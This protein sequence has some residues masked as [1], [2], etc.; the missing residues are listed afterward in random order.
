MMGAEPLSR[1]SGE[2][3]LVACALASRTRVAAARVEKIV[4]G[5]TGSHKFQ[6]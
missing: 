1:C 4:N 5:D 2:T 6:I 3:A